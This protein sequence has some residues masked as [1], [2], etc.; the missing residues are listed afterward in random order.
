[1]HKD[2]N[3]LK[4]IHA[5]LQIFVERKGNFFQC[6]DDNFMMFLQILLPSG[7]AVA[8]CQ[9]QIDQIKNCPGRG[10]IITGPAPQ[11]SGFDFYSRYFCQSWVSMR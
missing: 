8:E 7:E 9:P 3:H 6:H 4:A 5:S 2:K 11:G 1:M 10:M